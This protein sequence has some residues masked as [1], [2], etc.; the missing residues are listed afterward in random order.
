[1]ADYTAQYRFL[2]VM[3]SAHSSVPYKNPSSVVWKKAKL[4][5]VIL[6]KS[7]LEGSASPFLSY[8]CQ[9]A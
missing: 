8:H 7:K 1:M 9:D 6:V 5:R 3:G 4:T 2:T